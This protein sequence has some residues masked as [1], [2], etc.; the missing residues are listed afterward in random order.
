M[1]EI[2]RNEVIFQNQS[3]NHIDVIEI[4]CNLP[5]LINLYYEDPE[6][7]KVSNLVIGD[8]SILSLEKGKQQVLTFNIIENVPLIYSF[9]VEK[10]SLTNPEISIIFGDNIEEM[11]IT[12]NGIYS[13]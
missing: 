6:N 13:I 7:T 9:T 8:I 10:E 11:Q 3:I 2:S 12:Q 5:L 1:E 4:T